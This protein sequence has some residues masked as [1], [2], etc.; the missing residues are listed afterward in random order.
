[1]IQRK[2]NVHLDTSLFIA[3]PAGRLGLPNKAT[4]DK[5]NI[6]IV[7][8]YQRQSPKAKQAAVSMLASQYAE[9]SIFPLI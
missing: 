4:I 9:I 8:L 5:I 1:M 7:R 2:K 3:F 6:V